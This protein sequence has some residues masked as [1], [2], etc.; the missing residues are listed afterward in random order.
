MQVTQ[1]ASPELQTRDVRIKA[2]I[3]LVRRAHGCLS[4]RLVDI[5]TIEPALLGPLRASHANA[6]RRDA[7]SELLLLLA[8][9]LVRIGRCLAA[10]LLLLR[11][12]SLGESGPRHGGDH[13]KRGSSEKN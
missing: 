6:L 7:T 2:F 9:D 12:L 13:D 10:L 3:R 11:L 8:N 1:S 4:L 5:L